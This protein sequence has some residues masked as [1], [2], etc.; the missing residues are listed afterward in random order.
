VR[1]IGKGSP[2]QR[3]LH[4]KGDFVQDGRT[5]ERI[6]AAGV[7][8]RLLRSR[9]GTPPLVQATERFA[10]QIAVAVEIVFGHHPPYLQRPEEF[11]DQLRPIL[12]ELVRWPSSGSTGS[13]STTRIEATA[14]RSCSS[15]AGGEGRR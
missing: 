10:A 14:R 15:T 8:L 2:I 11:A 4:A 3:A 13:T 1:P 6:G 5:P 12:R 9:E 7:A